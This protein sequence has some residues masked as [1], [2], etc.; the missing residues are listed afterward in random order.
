MITD[1]LF[2]PTMIMMKVMMI[3]ITNG[4]NNNDNSLMNIIHI[5]MTRIIMIMAVH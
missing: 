2:I 5:A 4:E 1:I 3:M